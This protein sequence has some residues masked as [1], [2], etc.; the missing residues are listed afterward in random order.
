MDVLLIAL[1]SVGNEVRVH[2]PCDPRTHRMTKVPEVVLILDIP[3]SSGAPN[4]NLR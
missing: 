4:G 3:E 2:L 1:I